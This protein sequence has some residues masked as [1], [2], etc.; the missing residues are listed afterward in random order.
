VRAQLVKP[1]IVGALTGFAFLLT[2]MYSQALAIDRVNQPIV[3]ASCSTVPKNALLVAATAGHSSPAPR[4]HARHAPRA[5]HRRSASRS[6]TPGK[7]PSRSPTPSKTPTARPTGSSKPPTSSPSPAKSAGPTPSKTTSAS[8]TPSKSPGPTP[9]KTSS[10]SPSKSA[11]PS[12]P[13]ASPTPKPSSS[14]PE[15]TSSSPSPTASPTPSPTTPTPTPS[16]SPTPPAHKPTIPQLCDRVQS[17]SSASQ[18]RPG[19]VANFAIWV[20]SAK[21]PSHGVSVTVQVALAEYIGAP[22]FTVC[23][24]TDGKTCKLGNLPTGQ[25]DELQARIRVGAKAA[26][27]E[28]VQLTAKVTAKGAKSFAGS[29][30]DVVTAPAAQPSQTPPTVTLPPTLLPPIAGTGVTPSNPSGLFPTV[31]P[32]T[33]TP[34]A[35]PLGLPQV[36]PRHSFHV[37][38]AA[39]TVPLDPRLIGGQLAGLAVLAGA[40]ALAIA[41]LS[42]RTPKPPEDKNSKGS[43]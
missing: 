13:P 21:A 29:A 38:D 23:P 31:G 37:A 2:G 32:A 36:K 25:A 35:S 27:G 22:R 28:Q 20:W 16:S 4:V 15:S 14:T 8:P 17:F 41:R 42:L 39:A 40:V 1:T 11:A 34:S 19:Q 7:T 10:P 6:P 43:G 5:S 30:T 12:P 3:N 26:L 18:V 24:V 9:T 33:P